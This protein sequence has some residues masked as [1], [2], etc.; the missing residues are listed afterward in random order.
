MEQEIIKNEV[1]SNFVCERSFKMDLCAWDWAKL[2][3]IENFLK[4]KIDQNG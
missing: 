1:F 2:L 3:K 4:I